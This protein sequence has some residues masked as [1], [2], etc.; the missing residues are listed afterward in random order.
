MNDEVGITS[1]SS[2]RGESHTQRGGHRRAPGID[3]HQFNLASDDSRCEPGGQASD[4]AG[5]DHRD[6]IANVRSCIP[7][8]VEGRFEIR[9]QHRAGGRNAV[10]QQVH[11]VGGDDETGLMR[12]E[13][14][15]RAVGELAWAAYDAADGRIPVLHGRRKLAGL[16]R[17]T[18]AAPFA[19]RDAAV[20]HERLGAA[21]DAA[22]LRLHQ[23]LAV[24]RR[25][26]FLAADLAAAGRRHPER[27]RLILHA[28][29]F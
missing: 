28:W 14:E 25:P 3:V 11:R 8:A 27:S 17:R 19:R 24:R 5:A 29:T 22:V 18:H 26:Q 2:R 12:M 9:G 7:D 23:D 6:T 4:G 20:E 15:H 16:K 1:G 21:A 13:H 10:G